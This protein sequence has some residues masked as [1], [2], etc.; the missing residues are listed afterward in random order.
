M[1]L[2]TEDLAVLSMLPAT[3]SALVQAT[4]GREVL[5]HLETLRKTGLATPRA[6]AWHQGRDLTPDDDYQ[7]PDE[8][9]AL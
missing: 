3:K 1:K 8:D 4:G 9:G 6:G 5:R 2:T 7:R